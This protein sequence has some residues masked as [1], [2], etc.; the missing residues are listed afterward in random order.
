ME[1][2]TTLST[3]GSVAVA[4]GMDAVPAAAESHFTYKCF[5]CECLGT[6]KA[7]SDVGPTAG[8]ILPV[9]CTCSACAKGCVYSNISRCIKCGEDYSF[10]ASERHDIPGVFTCINKCSHERVSPATRSFL[11]IRKNMIDSPLPPWNRT[12][13]HSAV[14]ASDANLTWYL[15]QQGA[16]PFIRDRS[17]INCIDTAHSNLSAISEIEISSAS[18][19]SSESKNVSLDARI[20]LIVDI[21]PKLDSNCAKIP[22]LGRGLSEGSA[23]A[24]AINKCSASGPFKDPLPLPPLNKRFI[25]DPNKYPV[26][27]VAA[28]VAKSS[29]P[30]SELLVEPGDG[31]L[32]KGLQTFTPL[33]LISLTS[34]SE[35]VPPIIGEEMLEWRV[36][37]LCHLLAEEVTVEKPTLLSSSKVEKLEDSAKFTCSG[38]YDDLPIDR[39]KYSCRRLGCNG[40]LCE[41]CIVR[42]VYITI[43]TCLYA[44]PSIRCPGTCMH[45]IP[46][47][48]WRGA[49]VGVPAEPKMFDS[50]YQLL[51]MSNE[52]S[53]NRT[54]DSERLF[55]ARY[56]SNAEALL[57]MRCACCDGTI[58]LFYSGS[59]LVT[60]KSIR[61]DFFREFISLAFPDPAKGT[62]FLQLVM[63]YYNGEASAEMFIS[64]LIGAC[65]F[66][67]GEEVPPQGG[68]LGQN[69]A[70]LSKD[71]LCCILDIER[72]LCAQLMLF[73]IYP[74]IET[75]CCSYPHCFMCKIEG[76]HEEETCEEVQQREAG[77]EV[78]Y[79]TGCGV[80]TLRVEGCT[81]ILCVCGTN[82]T[83]DEPEFY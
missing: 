43:T 46:T 70:Q 81:D 11:R 41:D 59:E 22:L 5:R 17:G 61:Y 48:T 23:R 57:K 66:K 67:L 64:G 10:V 9:S 28:S 7:I 2:S 47:K 63:R 4:S 33:T 76:H 25:S 14:I 45:R 12:L 15:L 16:N 69:I 34:G 73:R 80:P 56:A 75:P 19:S 39:M 30:P 32:K 26:E 20:R 1:I 52:C 62:S 65:A 71:F 3:A 78:Q 6:Y 36:E 24:A 50:I 83:W 54:M 79:C 72:R 27:T 40:F 55:M 68:A 74:K 35:I 42:Y 60:D 38:C 29:D 82:W 31:L 37:E 18:T 58:G 44:V 21:L 77:I 13:L 53:I 8:A 51:L 49:L